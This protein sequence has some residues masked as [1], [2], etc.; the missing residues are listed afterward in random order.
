M[1]AH[2]RL[3]SLSGLVLASTAALLSLGCTT[4]V[5]VQDDEKTCTSIQKTEID[6]SQIRPIVEDIV[7][8]ATRR[9]QQQQRA[10][11][12]DLA[13]ACAGKTQCVVLVD[14]QCYA[15]SAR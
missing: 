13:Q 15:V 9:Q 10:A 6:Y 3:R 4:T 2:P 7:G 1:H 5:A 12:V 14:G 11:A 8:A